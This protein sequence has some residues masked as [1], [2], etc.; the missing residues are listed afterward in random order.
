MAAEGDTVRPAAVESLGGVS[1]CA[2]IE[3]VPGTSHPL[4][5]Q[6]SLKPLFVSLDAAANDRKKNLAVLDRIEK[7]LKPL[8]VEAEK[9]F[10]R[11]PQKDGAAPAFK[12]QAARTFLERW[13]FA[14][15]APLRVGRDR[16]EPATGLASAMLLAACRA[17]RRPDAIAL[18]RSLSGPEA[19]SQRAFTALLLLEAHRRDEALEFIP[20]L[21][22]EGFLAPYVAA[23]VATDASERERLHDLARRHVQT[24][25][26]DTAWHAQA[27]RFDSKPAVSPPAT[28]TKPK[29]QP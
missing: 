13:V 14:A 25:D 9:A 20:E 3:G 2:L 8:Y 16:I 23:E 26:Q 27:R 11:P 29:A 6:A 22:D 15:N 24:P 7:L 10:A 12:P 19:Q 18:G 5:M 28:D 17:D 21:G 1:A 4:R